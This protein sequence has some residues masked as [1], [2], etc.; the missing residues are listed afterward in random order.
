MVAMPAPMASPVQIPLSFLF[1]AV[2]GLTPSPTANITTK[3]T[4]FF[5]IFKPPFLFQF[6]YSTIL[7]ICQPQKTIA[8]LRLYYKN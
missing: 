8:I 4:T 1:F 6:K 7:K 2:A 5:F 3:K